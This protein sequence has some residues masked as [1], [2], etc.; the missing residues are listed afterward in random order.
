MDTL[1]IEAAIQMSATQLEFQKMFTGLLQAS[2]ATSWATCW[3]PTVRS[4][5]A[6][7]YT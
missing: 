4:M 5:T 6:P 3:H 1:R 7:R 2:A